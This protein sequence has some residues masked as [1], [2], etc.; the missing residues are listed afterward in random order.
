M[1]EI[2]AAAHASAARIEQRARENASA[3][4]DESRHKADEIMQA[5]RERASRLLARIDAFE[6]AIADNVADLRSEAEALHRALEPSGPEDEAVNA[7]TR[8]DPSPSESED[9]HALGPRDE[10]RSLLV[11]QIRDM[12]EAGR[13]REEA[14]QFLMRF[15]RGES[16]LD[17][18]DEVYGT[19]AAQAPAPESTRPLRRRR[20]R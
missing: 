19:E 3:I 13:D 16:H 5:A 18:L 7:I 15:K 1:Q 17:V 2:I 20:K 4:E 8:S 6:R 12:H 11:A 14:K 9:A 10:V